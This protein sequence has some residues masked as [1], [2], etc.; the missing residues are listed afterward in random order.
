MAGNF[1]PDNRNFAAQNTF[2]MIF[3]RIPNVTYFLQDSGIPGIDIPAARVGTPRK[4]I[5]FPGDQA[6][7]HPLE[8]SFMVDEDC[9]SWIEI[10]D[11]M[12]GVAS[13]STPYDRAEYE[14]TLRGETF[15]IKTASPIPG[16]AIT[17]PRV[18][19]QAMLHV[20]NS[21]NLPRL[22][23]KYLDIHPVK[24]SKIRLMTTEEDVR[25]L[26]A[27]AVFEYSIFHL[28]RIS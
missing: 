5:P 26:V 11:W 14:A 17:A 24:L 20:L 23:V 3:S 28:R 7:Y 21:N 8:M 12:K 18:E 13:P 22:E 6:T 10:H 2:R 19:A 16:H 4:S 1:Q 15:G 9:V 27:D 25:Y